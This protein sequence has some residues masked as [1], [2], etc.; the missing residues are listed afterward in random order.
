MKRLLLMVGL[1]ILMTG[2]VSHYNQLQGDIL[3]LYLKKPAAKQVAFACSLDGFEF[4]EA[5]QVAGQWVVSLPSSA[6][7]RYYYVVNGEPFLPPCRMKERDD[8]GSEN[9]IFEPD[10]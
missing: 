7:F 4:H 6:Q 9:C 1:M 10:L 3:V 8:F 5:Q 2:C